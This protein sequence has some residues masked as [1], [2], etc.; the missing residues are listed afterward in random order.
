MT[1]SYSRRF[2]REHTIDEEIRENLVDLEI[3]L[4]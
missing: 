2:D 3:F 1:L 4:P